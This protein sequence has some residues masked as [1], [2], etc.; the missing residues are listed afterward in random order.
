M[1]GTVERQTVAECVAALRLSGR[2]D[3]VAVVASLAVPVAVFLAGLASMHGTASALPAALALVS[4]SFAAG[5]ASAARSKVADIPTNLVPAC[6]VRWGTR[7]GT[8]IF[9]MGGGLLLLASRFLRIGR[10]S[11]D[12]Q[13]LAACVFLAALPTVAAGSLGCLAGMPRAGRPSAPPAGGPDMIGEDREPSAKRG[14]LPFAVGVFLLSLASP[15]VP[16]LTSARKLVADQQHV[17]AEREDFRHE[18]PA[19]LRGAEASRWRIVA[20]HH[21]PGLLPGATAARSR[22]G[23]LLAFTGEEANLT[24]FDLTRHAPLREF[25]EIPP[26]ESF[27]WSPDGRRIFCQCAGEGPPFRVLEADTGR[28][29][30]LPVRRGILAGTPRWSWE[31]EVGFFE[32]DSRVAALSLD[33][34]RVTYLSPGHSPEREAGQPTLPETDR[35]ALS[36]RPGIRSLTSPSGPGGSSWDFGAD[37]VLAVTDK[38]SGAS[39]PLIGPVE[40]GSVLLVAPDASKLTVV[41]GGGAV[42]HYVGLGDADDGA[43]DGALPRL[44]E[45][46]PG[47]PLRELRRDGRI[48]AFVCAPLVNPLNGKVVGPDTGKVRALALWDRDGAARSSLRITETYQPVQPGDVA[49]H[50]HYWDDGNPVLLAGGDLETRWTPDSRSAARGSGS[51]AAFPRW[52]GPDLLETPAGI[53]FQGLLEQQHRPAPALRDISGMVSK[54]RPPTA[55]PAAPRKPASSVPVEPAPEATEDRDEERIRRFVAEHHRKVGDRDLEGFVG[56]YADAVDL[57]DKG[58]VAPDFIRRDQAA[59]LPRYDELSETLAGEVEVVPIGGGWRVRY[60]IR[61]HAVKRADGK[62]FDRV[63][64]LTLDIRHDEHGGLEIFRERAD[65]P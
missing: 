24:V 7:T 52:P 33:T 19:D 25:R 12:W 5:A 1:S 48:G 9:L 21:L 6:A 8:I 61:S 18:V 11:E 2:G 32:G 60:P 26:V 38:L 34:L 53:G 15:A 57:N 36:I 40:E 46:E 65:T 41:D 49:G 59:Y 50:L 37:A 42:T 17:P 13:S 62:V 51:P 64:R 10:I 4:S 27:A 22:D 54:P 35:C 43:L 14:L 16:M 58:L 20:R 47:S 56:D 28:A 3:L 29:L 39:F 31:S 23:R 63:V 30:Q 44:P 45:C 55:A